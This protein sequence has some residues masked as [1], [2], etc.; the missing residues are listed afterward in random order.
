MWCQKD[1]KSK[2]VG[3]LAIQADGVMTV[4]G[5]FDSDAQAESYMQD[6]TLPWQ[7]IDITDIRQNVVAD[8]Y[9]VGAQ[10]IEKPAGTC[11][12]TDPG[13]PAIPGANSSVAAAL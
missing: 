13:G 4:F 5:P 11:A 6:V 8:V 10:V 3:V 9:V 12:H 1:G 2:C 7:L